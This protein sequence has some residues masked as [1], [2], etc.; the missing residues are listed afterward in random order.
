MPK[1]KTTAKKT[2]NQEKSTDYLIQ[3]ALDSVFDTDIPAMRSWFLRKQELNNGH[4]LMK[5]LMDGVL[6]DYGPFNIELLRNIPMKELSEEEFHRK[7]E[8]LLTKSSLNLFSNKLLLTNIPD[9]PTLTQNERL[10]LA[11]LKTLFKKQVDDYLEMIR[12]IT[13]CLGVHPDNP[14][15]SLR[16]INADIINEA[17]KKYSS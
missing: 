17:L 12:K 14:N 3:L 10:S 4:Y 11:F 16:T 6:G 7:K 8:L 15:L 1:R 2:A 13:P 5:H 9:D